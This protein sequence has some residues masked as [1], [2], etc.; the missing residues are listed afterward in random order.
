M[1]AARLETLA[2]GVHAWIGAGGD[3]NAGAVETPHGLLVIDA[4]Q[5][6]ELGESL[7]AALTVATGIPIWALVNTHY[8]LDHVA[9]NVA[10]ADVPIISHE[11]TLIALAAELGPGQ[12]GATAVADPMAKI[13]LFFGGNFADL[14]PETERTWFLQRVGGSAPVTIVPPSITFADRLEVHL[15]GDVIRMEYWG[16]AHC[17][18]DVVIWLENAGVVFLGDLCFYGRFPWFGDCDLDGWITTLDRVLAMKVATVIPGHGPPAT[19]REVA[20][21]RALLADLREAIQ[22]ALRA[23]LTEAAAAR[24]VVL[25][26]YAGMPR[27]QEWMAYNV[28]SAYRYLRAR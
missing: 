27:Y 20:Q 25:P 5:S 23:G 10:F 12:R 22:V 6:K 14:V 17:D 8:H 11:K 28:R 21:F 3:S 19:L 24:E 16:P 15:R 7:R 9:G 1:S 18:G 13:R 4:Q 26:Q 2:P